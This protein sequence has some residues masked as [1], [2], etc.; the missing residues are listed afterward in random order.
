MV[1]LSYRRA[2]DN[3]LDASPARK[4]RARGRI[5]QTLLDGGWRH[6]NRPKTFA[7]NPPRNPTIPQKVTNVSIYHKG[8]EPRTVGVV[9]AQTPSDRGYRGY[10]VTL[11]DL[12]RLYLN[13]VRSGHTGQRRA[14]RDAERSHASTVQ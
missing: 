3:G 10:I 14:A 6:P 5:E 8:S 12:Q 1:V 9:G 4:W 7:R 2:G 11:H 13:S